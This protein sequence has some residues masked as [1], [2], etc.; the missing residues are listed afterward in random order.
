MRLPAIVPDIK[1]LSEV[2]TKQNTLQTQVA[3]SA[4]TLLKEDDK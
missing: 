2:R 3:A 1:A 4:I